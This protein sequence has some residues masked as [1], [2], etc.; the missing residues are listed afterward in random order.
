MALYFLCFVLGINFKHG[1][2]E[3]RTGGFVVCS[4]QRICSLN[5]KIILCTHTTVLVLGHD[6]VFYIL[7]LVAMRLQGN[8]ESSSQTASI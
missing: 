3:N 7:Q 8:G 2:Q 4:T 6:E 1:H 5:S